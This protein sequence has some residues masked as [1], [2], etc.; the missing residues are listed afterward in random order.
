[1]I[2][3]IILTKINGIITKITQINYKMVT[4]NNRNGRN[5]YKVQIIIYNII[6]SQQK[7]NKKIM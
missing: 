3:I 5:V 1:M 6:I 2:K 7:T 4:K